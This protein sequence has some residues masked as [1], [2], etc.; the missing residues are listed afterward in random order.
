MRALLALLALHLAAGPVAWGSPPLAGQGPVASIPIVI[1]A[2]RV[3]VAEGVA[4]GERR[5]ASGHREWECK[6]YRV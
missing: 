2:D 4:V 6:L 3:T 1:H 5:A